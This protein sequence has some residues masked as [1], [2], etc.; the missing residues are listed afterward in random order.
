MV[1]Q[2]EL[3]DSFSTGQFLM[4]GFTAPYR[5]HRNGLGGGILVYNPED[6]TSKLLAIDF[7]NRDFFV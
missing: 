2:T 3:D 5:L 4:K 1:S 6:I 7:L